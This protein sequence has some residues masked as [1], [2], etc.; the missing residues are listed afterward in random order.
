MD[1]DALFND[2]YGSPDLNSGESENDDQLNEMNIR[3]KKESFRKKSS[4]SNES[5]RRS[6]ETPTPKPRLAKNNSKND[7]VE[8]NSDE[9]DF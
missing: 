1:D 6:V 7:N 5:D 8:N 2:N 3:M 9:D 4:D